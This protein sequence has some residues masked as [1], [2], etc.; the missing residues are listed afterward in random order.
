MVEVGGGGG[1]C[2]GGGGGDV[3]DGGDKKMGGV[4]EF[5]TPR[6]TERVGRKRRPKAGVAPL[7]PFRA[8]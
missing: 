4:R 7:A 3:V 2:G 1:G 6:E 8:A 5:A